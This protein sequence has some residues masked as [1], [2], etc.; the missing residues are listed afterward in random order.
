ML[1]WTKRLRLIA[2]ER[3]VTCL[4]SSVEATIAL[5]Y[6]Y[7]ISWGQPRVLREK[8]LISLESV[9]VEQTYTDRYHPDPPILPMEDGTIKDGTDFR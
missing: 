7:I 8:W 3:R 6:T 4:T 5:L 2:T 9:D 1:L